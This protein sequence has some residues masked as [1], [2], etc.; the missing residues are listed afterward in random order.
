MDNRDDLQKE[1]LNQLD[2]ARVNFQNIVTTIIDRDTGLWIHDQTPETHELKV[3]KQSLRPIMNRIR[4]RAD[5][6]SIA[7]LEGIEEKLGFLLGRLENGDTALDIRPFEVRKIAFEYL[8]DA[9]DQYLHLPISLSRTEPLHHGRT[10]DE[11][12]H[13]QLELLDNTL[14]KL[15]K[16]LFEQDARGL[17][18]HG[19]FLKEKFADQA[20]G[21]IHTY[22]DEPL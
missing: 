20:H 5:A 10:A 1:L 8:P 19:R 16:S 11:S 6:P 3:W 17:L 9:L 7:L 4:E 18:V 22:G 13:E 12:L 14:N 21:Q 2:D 15:A